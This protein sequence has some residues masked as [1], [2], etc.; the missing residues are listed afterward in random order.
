[1]SNQF[2]VFYEKCPVPHFRQF[3]VHRVRGGDRVSAA[4][5]TSGVEARFPVRTG[6]IPRVRSFPAVRSRTQQASCGSDFFDAGDGGFVDL[7]GGAL[8]GPAEGEASCE[9]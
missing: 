4:G 8:E 1:M 3:A 7:A 2:L 6:Q 9:G 5:K